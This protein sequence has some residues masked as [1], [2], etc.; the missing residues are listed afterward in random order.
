MEV[1]YSL[2]RIRVLLDELAEGERTLEHIDIGQA[3]RRLPIVHRSCLTL[4]AQGYP[5]AKIA[6]KVFGGKSKLHQEVTEEWLEAGDMRL[7]LEV[8]GDKKQTYGDTTTVP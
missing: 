7:Y 5:T 1:E 6:Q 2:F 3:L 4:R 8:N